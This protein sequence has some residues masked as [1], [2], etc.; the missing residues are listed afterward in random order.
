MSNKLF[1]LFVPVLFVSTSLFSC[2]SSNSTSSIK[3]TINDMYLDQVNELLDSKF[4]L[5]FDDN[6][7]FKIIS[8]V[9]N[10]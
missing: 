9:I 2:G 7:K 5:E 1:K 6:D 3:T 10:I 8:K 4:N